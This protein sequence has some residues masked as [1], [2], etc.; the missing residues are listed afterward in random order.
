MIYQEYFQLPLTMSEFSYKIVWTDDHNR[1]FDFNCSVSKEDAMK[2]VDKLN[3]NYD[4]KIDG[5]LS[6]DGKGH[7]LLNGIQILF[8]RSWGRLTGGGALNLPAK[9][10]A[11]IQDSFAEW[12]INTLTKE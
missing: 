1:A 12:I 4:K 8:I 11:E 5:E 9:E 6:Y 2:V 7:I 10:A 3:G